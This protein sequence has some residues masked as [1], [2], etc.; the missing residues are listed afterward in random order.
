MSGPLPSDRD[1]VEF[2]RMVSE[3]QLAFTEAWFAM[4]TQSFTAWQSISTAML[5]SVWSPWIGGSS[6]PPELA[7]RMQAATLDV[8]GKGLA[9]V[10]RTAVANAKR[11]SRTTL[12]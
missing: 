7:S 11:L 3:K 9:P 10:H 1:R 4:V 6:A 5:C 12:R 2:T 8:L